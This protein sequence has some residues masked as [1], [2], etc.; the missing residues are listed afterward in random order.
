MKRILL[1]ILFAFVCT[2]VCMP[3]MTGIC[4]SEHWLVSSPRS[5][6]SRQGLSAAVLCSLGC[7]PVSFILPSLRVCASVLELWVLVFTSGTLYALQGLNS[8][9]MPP[10]P[11]A[12]IC[13]AFSLV[14]LPL[15]KAF[16]SAWFLKWVH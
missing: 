8:G 14:L 5:A 12:F 6:L 1:F 4:M 15:L 9:H 2:H 16:N 10:V 7:W 3:S 13:P 11:S